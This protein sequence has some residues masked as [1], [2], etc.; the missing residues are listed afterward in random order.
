MA[1]FAFIGGG[2]S[3]V[4]A[5][6][7]ANALVQNKGESSYGMNDAK[8]ALLFCTILAFQFGLQV[9]HIITTTHLQT[10]YYYS[11]LQPMCHHLN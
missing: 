5:A 9:R 7:A 4:F 2:P 3:Q 10:D 1:L 8:K 11:T 6:G